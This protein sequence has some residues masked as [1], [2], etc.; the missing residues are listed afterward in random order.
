MPMTVVMAVDVEGEELVEGGPYPVLLRVV[1][2]HRQDLIA[3]GL[4]R[5]V[6]VTSL[7]FRSRIQKA[8]GDRL[9]YTLDQGKTSPIQHKNTAEYFNIFLSHRSFFSPDKASN[10]HSPEIRSQVIKC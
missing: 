7:C 1:A 10:L 4:G 9:R 5:P 2:A 6:F 3:R 8:E